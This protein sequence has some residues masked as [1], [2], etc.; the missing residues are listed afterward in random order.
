[1]WVWPTGQEQALGRHYKVSLVSLLWALTLVSATRSPWFLESKCPTPPPWS[2]PAAKSLDSSCSPPPTLPVRPGFSRGYTRE[3][4]I[5][6]GVLA[7][8]MSPRR[9]LIPTHSNL[10]SASRC[11]PIVP[12]LP[13]SNWQPSQVL[14]T[15]LVFL[16]ACSWRSPDRLQIHASVSLNLSLGPTHCWIRCTCRDHSSC[17]P[18]SP[19]P[20]VSQG[21]CG[22]Q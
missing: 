20:E 19:D 17:T 6:G 21:K 4:S 12:H 13:R 7:S 18:S 10:L 3:S 14:P 8:D 9:S 15:C 16:I 1:M 22:H 11:L 5:L 2:L